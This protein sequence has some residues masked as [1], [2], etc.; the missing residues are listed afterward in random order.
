MANI[1]Q[2]YTLGKLASLPGTMST[3]VDYILVTWLPIIVQ[4]LLVI[5]LTAQYLTALR[6]AAA[7]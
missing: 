7:N 3:G 2:V 5:R 1:Q 4:Q 6:L